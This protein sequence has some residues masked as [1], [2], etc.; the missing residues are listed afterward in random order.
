MQMNEFNSIRVSQK[1]KYTKQSF[2]FIE[3]TEYE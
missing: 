2:T 1:S 3:S